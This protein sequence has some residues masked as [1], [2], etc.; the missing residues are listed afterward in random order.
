MGPLER[1]RRKKPMKDFFNVLL[2]TFAVSAES[3]D[4]SDSHE[5]YRWSADS[6]KYQHA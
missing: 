2:I 6:I 3:D 5:M 1:R 4:A